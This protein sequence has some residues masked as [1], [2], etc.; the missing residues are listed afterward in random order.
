MIP[1][2]AARAHISV[3]GELRSREY[4]SIG[5]K[6]RTHDIVASSIINLRA[7]RTGSAWVVARVKD[8]WK[9]IQPE[10]PSSLSPKR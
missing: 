4:G 1:A 5:S 3:E 7:G 9:Q 2:A 10:K 8:D 6:T